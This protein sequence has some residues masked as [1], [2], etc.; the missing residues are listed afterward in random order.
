MARKNPIPDSEAQIC[1]RVRELRLGSKLS[2]VAFANLIGIDSSRLA[3]YEHGRVPLGFDVGIRI[4]TTFGISP[5]W[6]FDGS[7]PQYLSFKLPDEI[8]A[9]IPA[10][11]L[12][13][14]MFQHIQQLTY[15]ALSRNTSSNS[16]VAILAGIEHYADHL[17]KDEALDSR[18]IFAHL[19]EELTGLQPF[20]PP[21]LLRKFYLVMNEAMNAFLRQNTAIMHQWSQRSLDV[22]KEYL[23]SSSSLDKTSLVKAQLPSLLER[24]KRAT[25][26]AGKMSDLADFLNAPLA[27]VSRWLSGKREP[28]GEITLK[29]LRWVEQQERVK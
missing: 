14:E 15:E 13:S 28:G 7:G 12:Y 6:L 5:R 2:Q 3:S 27:S 1:R 19:L 4:I 11:R 20:I 16:R 10:R 21:H 18:R 22:A 9:Q 17:E 29:M 8:L 26:E 24:L 25:Q 23:T